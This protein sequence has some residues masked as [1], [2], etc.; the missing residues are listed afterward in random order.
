MHI[1]L[2]AGALWAAVLALIVPGLIRW[3]RTQK[4]HYE[5]RLVRS[6]ERFHIFLR[7]ESLRWLGLGSAVFALALSG[8]LFGMLW[9]APLLLLGI[10][11]AILVLTKFRLS[12]RYRL[13]RY[14]LPA[15]IELLATSLRAGLSVRAALSQ[16]VSQSARPI[17]QELAMLDRMQ[18]IG[19]PLD[20]ALSAWSQRLPVQ[21]LQL[22]A[23]AINVSAASGGSLSDALDRLAASFRQRLIL[24]EKV[25]ALTAQGRL[26]AWVMV[27]LP[28]LLALALTLIDPDSMASLWASREGNTVL[29]A[30]VLLEL[31]G[32]LWIRRLIRI[33]D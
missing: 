33:Q 32:L 24:E 13:I 21:E 10:L 30:V 3:S 15:V 7:I 8:L 6:L 19:M 28:G 12:R 18:R 5:D 25:D 29:V 16:L 27:A 17:S 23:F 26:Q 11:T 2:L 20:R 31:V 14:Q 9:I 1:G 22:L 4:S